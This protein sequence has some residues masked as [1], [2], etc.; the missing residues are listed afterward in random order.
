M[1]RRPITP[2]DRVVIALSTV[3]RWL[4]EL[5]MVWG[6]VYPETGP[7]TAITLTCIAVG[8]EANYFNNENTKGGLRF[9]A[10]II[11]KDRESRL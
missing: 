5:G 1:A 7:W 8:I 3:V 9:L 6:L 4:L 10:D 2:N 11:E